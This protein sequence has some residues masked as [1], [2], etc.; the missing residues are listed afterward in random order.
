MESPDIA[1][2]GGRPATATSPT[3][4][5]PVVEDGEADAVP[6]ATPDTETFKE[7]RGLLRR[8]KLLEKKKQ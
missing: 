6:A 3:V 8:R 4:A 5:T 1:S 2:P 7:M